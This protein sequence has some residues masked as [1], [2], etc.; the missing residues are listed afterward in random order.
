[1]GIIGVVILGV[2]SKAPRL[3]AH[4]KN[5]LERLQLAFENFKYASKPANLNQNHQPAN[6]FA[7][8]DPLLLSV[9]IFG[10]AALAGTA[11]DGYNQAF[12]KAQQGQ[13]TSGGSSCGSGCGT[14]SDSSSCSSGDGGGSC[15]GGCGGGGCGGC[16]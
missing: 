2:M 9:G 3:T 11:Y 14:S 15:S 12:H 8:V 1:M 6:S 7:A 13:S 10:T 4:G 5:Y 16:G